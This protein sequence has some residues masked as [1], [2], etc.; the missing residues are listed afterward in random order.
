[1]KEQFESISAMCQELLDKGPVDPTLGI[2]NSLSQRNG[3][4]YYKVVSLLD[5]IVE[6]WPKFSGNHLYPIPCD[7]TDYTNPAD[8]FNALDYL[9]E[10]VQGELRFELLR[11]IIQQCERKILNLSFPGRDIGPFRALL[12]E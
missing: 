6:A 7:G 8:C 4:G 3:R 2:C 9:W 10:G 12:V 1:M 5:E 11:Y